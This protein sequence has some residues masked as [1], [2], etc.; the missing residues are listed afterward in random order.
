MFPQLGSPLIAVTPVI[1]I[2]HSERHCTPLSCSS[3]HSCAAWLQL[4]RL[5]C[6]SLL[7]TPVLCI[8]LRLC[9]PTLRIHSWGLQHWAVA[10]SMS[11]YSIILLIDEQFS[12]Y[13]AHHW[14]VATSMSIYIVASLPLPLYLGI[15]LL[16]KQQETKLVSLL[17]CSSMSSSHII[18]LII[19]QL[20]FPC[21]LYS[22]ILATCRVIADLL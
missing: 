6:C 1:G 11:T 19:E 15:L 7:W 9:R 5:T 17:Y 14:A 3:V 13:T 16:A 22:G 2:G 4:S 8:V 21:W 12:Y 10:T 18:L 20:W